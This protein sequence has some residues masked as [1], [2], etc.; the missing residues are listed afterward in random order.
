[1]PIFDRRKLPRI[2]PSDDDRSGSEQVF[3][4]VSAHHAALIKMYD[5]TGKSCVELIG[6][7]R[8]NLPGNIVLDEPGKVVDSGM[9]R[10]YLKTGF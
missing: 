7:S 1:L 10:S 4:K 8:P 9:A 5:L 6:E 2:A 3:S